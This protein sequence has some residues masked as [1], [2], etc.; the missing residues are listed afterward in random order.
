MLFE[1]NK[2]K[3]KKNIFTIKPNNSYK[4][5]NKRKFNTSILNLINANKSIYDICSKE[6]TTKLNNNNYFNKY[7]IYN[8]NNFNNNRTRK[9]IFSQIINKYNNNNYNEKEKENLNKQNIGNSFKIKNN[10]KENYELNIFL[11]NKELEKKNLYKNIQIIKYD[12]DFSTKSIDKKNKLKPKLKFKTIS[13]KKNNISTFY[14]SNNN[15]LIDINSKNEEKN[16]ILSSKNNIFN[17]K[18]QKNLNKRKVNSLCQTKLSIFDQKEEDNKNELYMN[19]NGKNRSIFPSLYI[20]KS[21]VKELLDINRN[22]KIEKRNNFI[23][24]ENDKTKS[25]QISL[26][27]YKNK[28]RLNKVLINNKIREIRFEKKKN[29][30]CLVNNYYLYL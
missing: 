9:K 26:D 15:S 18:I 19:M 5:P 12:K 13:I 20:N 29:P 30:I 10:A 24:N 22:D 27:L 3:I 1:K 6:I 23:S 8:Y 11:K 4:I 25:Q 21:R 2:N 14:Y 7:D 17:I 28:F 16:S